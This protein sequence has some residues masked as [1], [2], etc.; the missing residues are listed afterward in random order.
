MRS[1]VA[2]A[3]VL[4]ALA[5][6][7]A[8]CGSQSRTFTIGVITDCEGV[9]AGFSPDSLAGAELPLLERGAKLAGR[10]PRDGVRGAR[11]AGRRV[12]L[13]QGCG[14]ITYL[15]QLIENVRRMIEAER[16][17]VVVAP[18]LG[19]AEGIVL[20]ELARRYP[21]VIF[22]LADSWAQEPTLRSPAANLFRFVGDDAQGMAGVGSYAY[23]DLGWRTAA[24]V[25]GDDSYSWPEA[26]G[27]VAEFCALGGRVRRVQAPYLSTASVV[28]RLPPG[29]DGVALISRSFPDTAGFAARYARLRPELARHLVLGSGALDFVDS[30][31]FAKA[32]PMLRGV[33]LGGPSRDASAP[34]WRA[35]SVS[36]HTHFPGLG[37]P[38]N[39]DDS[40]FR[41]GFYDSVEAT[42]RALERAQTEGEPLSRALA[43]TSFDAPD[44]PVRLDRDRQAIVSASLSRIDV[45]SKGPL[46][47]T[48][49]VLPGVE[50]TFAGYF[51]PHTPTPTVSQPGCH[52]G[53]VPPWAK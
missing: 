2:A 32:A 16:A 39:P 17:D 28:K 10:L 29:V 40:V 25:L 27:F 22:L 52:T 26:A 34:A 19:Q 23:H 6:L 24:L 14:E 13:V 41:L 5:L 3:A 48:V 35:F 8:G 31:L 49:R 21:K 37:T 12:R 30:K 38:R 47:H 45:T 9:F 15:T 1:R 36:F 53:K 46:I 42:L 51:G 44:G 43:A 50:Q 20:R 4:A 33:V 18:M 7:A 11:V